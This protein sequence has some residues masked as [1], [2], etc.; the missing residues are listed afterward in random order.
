MRNALWLH[1][2]DN[3]SGESSL[4]S[5][6]S[7]LAA[8]D[9]VVGLTWDTCANRG[10]IPYG[11]RVESKGNPVDL[12]SR[13]DKTGP[14]R[15]VVPGILP[16]AKL[17]ALAEELGSLVAARGDQAPLKIWQMAKSKSSVQVTE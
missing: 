5:G 16:E 6:T 12:L 4:I 7:A 15:G 10:L 1:L 11:D 3:E 9:L 8:A 2:I 13:G 17:E 14:C